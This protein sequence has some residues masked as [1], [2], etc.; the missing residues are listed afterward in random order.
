VTTRVPADSVVAGDVPVDATLPAIGI[1]EISSVPL[2]A[3]DAQA[4][5]S[6][7]TSRVQVTAESRTY[8]EVK[9]LLDLVRH[10]CNFQR[11]TLA[12]VD[13]ISIVRDTVGPDLQDMAGTYSQSI[14]FK[15]TYHEIN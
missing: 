4:E 14:D 2:G 1:K 6:V 15:V 11:G 8:P 7:V 13:V 5:Y 3:F 12:G 9:A 10:A